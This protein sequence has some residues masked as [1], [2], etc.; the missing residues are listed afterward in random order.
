MNQALYAHMNNKRK[1]KKKDKKIKNKI[2][3]RESQHWG[4]PLL[5]SKEWPSPKL[6]LFPNRDWVGF[7]WVVSLGAQ[8]RKTHNWVT[9][10]SPTKAW[11][12]S[13][14]WLVKVSASLFLCSSASM[15][16]SVPQPRFVSGSPFL[17]LG[18]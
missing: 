16:Q 1:M 2:P 10:S 11:L 9:G 8:N 17:V 18:L 4:L 7:V 14:R 5:W 15:P 12:A 3:L 13:Y 6:P